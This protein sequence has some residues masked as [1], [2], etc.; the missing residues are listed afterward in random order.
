MARVV[1][2]S[3]LLGDGRREAVAGYA[4]EPP[5]RLGVD[6]ITLFNRRGQELVHVKNPVLASSIPARETNREHVRQALAGHEITTVHEM[7]SG[8]MIQAVVPVRDPEQGGV[9]AAMVVGI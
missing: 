5:D 1:E 6:A 7:D 9:A 2:K 4:A 8:D 3:G